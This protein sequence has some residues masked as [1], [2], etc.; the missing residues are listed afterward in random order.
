MFRKIMERLRIFANPKALMEA[1]HDYHFPRE[2][3]QVNRRQTAY[4]YTDG[5]MMYLGQQIVK[6]MQDAGYPAK[7][8]YCHR[9]AEI[10][11]G[12]Y[13]QGRTAPGPK[14]TNARP[15]Q[16][17]HQYYEAVDIIHPSKGW[18]VSEGY[19]ETLAACVRNVAEKFNV[20][21]NHGHHWRFRD[22]AHIELS[23]WRSVKRAHLSRVDGEGQRRPPNADE[24]WARFEEVLP[25]VAKARMKRK[26]RR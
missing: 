24:L 6:Q 25:D 3:G 2:A 16:S 23:N 15:W 19:W 26:G 5:P 13:A 14:V 7:I 4:T 20:D 17:A 1:A 21:L 10:Q 8:L 11:A 12:L 22:S 18:N 9:S